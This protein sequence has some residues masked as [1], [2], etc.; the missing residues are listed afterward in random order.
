MISLYNLVHSEDGLLEP[1]YV[2][3]IRFW[4]NSVMYDVYILGALYS[5]IT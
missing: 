1:K 4:V 5:Y 2:A 3:A